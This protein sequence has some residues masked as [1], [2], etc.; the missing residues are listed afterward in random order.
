MEMDM[1]FDKQVYSINTLYA[2]QLTSSLDKSKDKNNNN[3][4]N[5]NKKNTEKRRQQ[6]ESWNVAESQ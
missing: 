4:S 2:S 3:N 1:I 5:N 6:T